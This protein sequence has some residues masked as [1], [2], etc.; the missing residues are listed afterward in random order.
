M[1]R[2]VI[3]AIVELFQENNM[4]DKKSENFNAMRS[5][6]AAGRSIK[7]IFH[8]IFDKLLF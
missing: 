6:S 1:Q 3:L 8:F 7:S 5:V 2:A 4:N